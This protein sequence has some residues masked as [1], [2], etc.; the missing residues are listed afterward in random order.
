[1]NIILSNLKKLQTSQIKFNMPK[2]IAFFSQTGSEIVQISQKIGRWPDII[3][4]NKSIENICTINNELLT[5]CFDKILFLPLKPTVAEYRTA[6]ESAQLSD[7]ITLNGWLR[8]IPEEVCSLY[9]IYNGHPGDII[10]YPQLKGIN[11]QQ[12]AFDLLLPTSG[13]IIHRVIPEVDSGS[14]EMSSE[15]KIDLFSI[16]N[17][18]KILHEN[19]INL[20]VEFLSKKLNINL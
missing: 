18:Y 17:T 14:I 5:E 8:I 1:L 7:I 2:W 6:L 4:T 10:N 19:S 12:K 16:C 11:P 3:C 13:S 9:N 15:C 20:W